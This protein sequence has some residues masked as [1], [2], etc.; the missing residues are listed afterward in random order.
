MELVQ[1]IVELT[2][3]SFQIVEMRN[4]IAIFS[5]AGFEVEIYGL[6]TSKL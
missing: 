2:T 1:R 3:A 6:E 5:N 4:A